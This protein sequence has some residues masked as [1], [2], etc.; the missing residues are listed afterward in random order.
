MSSSILTTLHLPPP[1]TQQKCCANTQRCTTYTCAANSATNPSAPTLTSCAPVACLG[2]Q[3]ATQNN[4]LAGCQSLCCGAVVPANP[5]CPYNSA[6]A[7]DRNSW[8]VYRWQN[9][10][11][12][13]RYSPITRGAQCATLD[14]RNCIQY[15]TSA[16]ATAAIARIRLRTL[17]VL[18]YC[19]PASAY[20]C[21]S[22]CTGALTFLGY[23]SR[24]AHVCTKSTR[25]HPFVNVVRGSTHTW[26]A[27]H[28]LFIYRRC[29][30]RTRHCAVFRNLDCRMDE[31]ASL[32][33]LAKVS[34]QCVKERNS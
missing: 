7:T 31:C 15:A 12:L 8:R 21:N 3:C 25:A 16:L 30:S 1:T 20:T 14:A 11:V 6:S 26:Y 34:P 19:C 5:S 18:P 9:K 28:L 17:S 10:F 29:A 2:S 13:V 4:N 33:G 24:C 27:A 32:H 22:F 23:G